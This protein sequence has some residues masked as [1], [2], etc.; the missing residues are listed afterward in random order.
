[1]ATP[2][3]PR[4]EDET[5][6]EAVRPT[7]PRPKPKPKTKTAP[8]PRVAPG[9]AGAVDGAGA[10]AE[11]RGA[12][13]RRPPSLGRR[14]VGPVRAHAGDRPRRLRPDLPHLAPGRV[15][16]P[17]EHP[18]RRRRAARRQPRRSDPAPMRRRSCTASRRSWAAPSTGWPTTCSSDCRW[19]AR[20]GR[21][22]A[23]S[24]PTPTTPTGSCARQHQ[25]VLVFPEGTKGTGKHYRERY[26]L[27]RFG[28]G[29]FVQI[30]M[31]AGVPDRAH[32]RRRRRGVD[33][34]RLQERH[35]GQA[36]RAP[37][38]ADHR[39][40][41]GLRPLGRHARPPGQDPHAGARAGAPSTWS[42]TGPA[43]HA[44]RSWTSPSASGSDIQEALYDMLRTRRV[45][46][47]R[48]GDGQAASSSP[49]SAPS[50][51]G[52]L[53]QA[54]EPDPGI[55]VIVGLDRYEPTVPL[56]RTEY[57]RSDES[58]SILARI[59]KA[60]KIDTI[61]HTFLV[62]DSTQMPRP[63]DP[64]DQRD[65]HHEPLRGGV[66]PRL[67]RAQRRGEVV[68]PRVRHRRQGPGVVHREL[69][70]R[71]AAHVHARAQ[72]AGGG[73]LRARLRRR[74]PPRRRRPP[75]LQQRARPRH[76]DAGGQGAGD[77]GRAGGG[78]VRPPA[79]VRARERRRARHPLRARPG[80]G[81]HVQRGR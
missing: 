6:P 21:A 9:G 15:G 34:D 41:A 27:R 14:R 66:R 77:A 18:H 47:V 60:A 1:M 49:A 58:Y 55:D 32:R 13:P 17:G 3:R 61:I 40:H 44:A 72:P 7:K 29:G 46:L 65:R 5:A 36:A 30:A 25:L 67:H 53:A 71:Q 8:R 63:D 31:R 22:S 70:P 69:A 50:G 11:A 51:A 68:H 24:S 79:A 12:R 56:E 54:L 39:Q 10:H 73:G 57:V 81:R 38:R 45:D 4:P 2:P 64:R 78:R 48:L 33:A 80:P 35:P 52:R 28:R 26:Q 19:S 62:V 23:G 74:Q 59:V 42:P 20:C 76:H 75:A 37:V 16:G 43:T